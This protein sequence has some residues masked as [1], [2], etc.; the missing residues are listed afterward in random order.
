MAL[1]PEYGASLLNPFDEQGRRVFE[2]AFSLYRGML[3]SHPWSMTLLSR[4]QVLILDVM[5]GSGLGST[6]LAK[7]LASKGVKPRVLVSDT[8]GGLLRMAERWGARIG[9]EV[10]VV[11]ADPG[12]TDIPGEEFDAV[13]LHTHPPELIDPWRMMRLLARISWK[14]SERSLLITRTTDYIY[15]WIREG[16]SRLSAFRDMDNN[17]YIDVLEEYDPSRG[18]L[19]KALVKPGEK[20]IGEIDITP[21][22]LAHLA[23]ILWLFFHDVDTHPKPLSPR[24]PFILLGYRPRRKL[25]PEE[26]EEPSLLRE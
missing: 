20:N 26:L 18:T 3:S 15:R 10:H 23:S 7:A 11:E 17:L 22:S 25:S 12:S 6:A 9:I 8:R 21:W 1:P 16:F 24:R 14:M 5:G 4:K 2:E 19:R 13:L